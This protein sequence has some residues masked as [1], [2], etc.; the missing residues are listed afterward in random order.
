MAAWTK[1]EEDILRRGHADGV[2]WSRLVDV[3]DGRKPKLIAD[4]ARRMKLLP[5]NSTKEPKIESPNENVIRDRAFQRAMLRA[6][7][8]GE[9][10]AVVGVI[11]DNTPF[12]ARSMRGEP[13]SSLCGSTSQMCAEA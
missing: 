11:V 6:I 13:S 5:L 1:A 10:T 12:S 9:E 3:L 8:S 7:E 2:K 4:K